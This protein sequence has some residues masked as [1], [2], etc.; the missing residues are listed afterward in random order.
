MKKEI[1]NSLNYRKEKK[2]ELKIIPRK[3]YE[4]II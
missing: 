4:N 1:K 3:K 2:E